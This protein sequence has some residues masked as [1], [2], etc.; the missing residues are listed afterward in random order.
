MGRDYLK[1]HIRE[2][3][4]EEEPQDKIRYRFYVSVDVLAEKSQASLGNLKLHV[5]YF[6]NKTDD[7]EIYLTFTNWKESRR[8]AVE[9]LGKTNEV[10]P[11]DMKINS[12]LLVWIDACGELK[13]KLD[14]EMAI[15]QCADVSKWLDVKRIEVTLIAIRHSRGLQEFFNVQYEIRPTMSK[16]S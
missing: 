15:L 3:E 14:G 16:L 9:G 7:K 10:T 6:K 1:V 4:Y 13:V 2:K 5:S 11:A 12:Q 8:C